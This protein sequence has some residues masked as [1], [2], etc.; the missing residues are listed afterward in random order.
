MWTP[1]VSHGLSAAIGRTP[2]IELPS[3]SAATGCRILV[4]AEL[5][6]PGGSVKDR[7]AVYILDG[8]ER[9]GKLVPRH[10]RAPGAPRGTI[11]EGTG[12]NTGI[13]LALLAASR[14]YNAIFTMPANVSDEKVATARAL[15]A[16]VIVCPVVPFTDPRHYYHAAQRIAAERGAVW[17]NQ[18]EGLL[19]AR[20]HAEGT[21]PEIWAQA[22]ESVDALVVAAGTGGTMGGLSTYLRS[23]NPGVKVYLA[24]PPGSSLAGYVTTGVMAPAP[25]NTITEGI[26]VGRLTANFA[27]AARID[28]AFPV[29]D[30]ETVDMALYLLRRE[31]LWVGPSAALN[32]CGAVKA[33][34]LLGPGHSVVTVLCD[35]GARYSSKMYSGAA[36]LA[37]R[38]LSDS[39]GADCDRDHADFVR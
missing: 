14:G 8:A 24:D 10:L 30:Q 6:N 35:G 36:W 15:G 3:L 11:V 22:G 16:E 7:A 23:V 19:N 18:F 26:G 1:R 4:K 17:G 31:G 37:E 12:G 38:G 32:V 2:L 33:A 39:V 28:G 34:R 9:E 21:G 29:S 13:A 20:S 25:G 27:S 5:L